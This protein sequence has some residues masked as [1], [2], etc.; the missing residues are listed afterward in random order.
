MDDA[1]G[2]AFTITPPTS[3]TLLSDIIPP[4][5]EAGGEPLALYY[6]LLLLHIDGVIEPFA[7]GR[8][9]LPMGVTR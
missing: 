3:A 7:E 1:S 2:G 4:Q 9:I 8:I 5:T 6:D